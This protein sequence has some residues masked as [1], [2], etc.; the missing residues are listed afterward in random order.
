MC[1]HIIFSSVWFAEWSP[2]GKKLLT[3][4]T[5][6]VLFAFGLFVILVYS[7]ILVL[8]AGCFSSWSFYTFYFSQSRLFLQRGLFQRT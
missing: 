7:R 8:R 1:V 2:F 3:R 4:L 6:Y 5:I